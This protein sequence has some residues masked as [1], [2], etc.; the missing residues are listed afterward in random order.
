MFPT[1]MRERNEAILAR[2]LEDHTATIQVRVA[3]E[4]AQD[5]IHRAAPFRVRNGHLA[6]AHIER[7]RKGDVKPD[8][9]LVAAGAVY[10]AERLEPVGSTGVPVN[11]HT[12]KALLYRVG[13]RV[14][15][16]RPFEVRGGRYDRDTRKFAPSNPKSPTAIPRRLVGQCVNA[17]LGIFFVNIA[18][19]LQQKTLEED[20]RNR[21]LS[22]PFDVTPSTHTS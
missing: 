19:S 20:E 17:H 13:Y 3:R 1:K 15:A 11:D 7:L 21:V 22:S 4:V 8:E 16:L 12:N 10:L 14:L 9:V 18:S 6:T 5:L 2:F